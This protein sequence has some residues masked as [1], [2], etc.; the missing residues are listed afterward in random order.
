MTTFEIIVCVAIIV[1]TFLVFFGL[2]FYAYF[3]QPLQEEH[4]KER[5]NRN[6]F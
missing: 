6:D 1:F 2:S 4:N 5:S 3:I